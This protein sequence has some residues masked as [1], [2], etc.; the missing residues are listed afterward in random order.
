MKFL[1]AMIV[2]FLFG[3]AAVVAFAVGSNQDVREVFAKARR[4]VESIDMEAIG[5]QFQDGVGQASAQMEK[6]VSKAQARA[7]QAADDAQGTAAEARD[8]VAGSLEK[9]QAKVAEGVDATVD[10]EPFE[11]A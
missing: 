8:D 10:T 9:M 3:I 1:V 11:N 6:T 5:A 4:D 2:G 7:G